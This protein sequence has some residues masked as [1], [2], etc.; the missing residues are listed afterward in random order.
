MSKRPILDLR[1]DD[2]DSDVDVDDEFSED[3]I[4]DE[5]P[6]MPAKK[7][8]PMGASA[9]I[10]DEA[11]VDDDAEDDEEEWEEGA[12]KEMMR[13]DREVVDED[14]EYRMRL[15]QMM[16]ARG[17]DEIEEY[18][19]KKYAETDD[20]EQVD[21]GN[22]AHNEEVKQQS[23]LPGVKDPN[24][25]RVKCRIGDEQITAIKLMRKF[26]NLE[27]NDAPLQIKSVVVP[28]GVK[29]CVYMEAYKQAHVKAALTGISS[30]NLGKWTQTMVP[31]KEM[32]DVL[33]VVNEPLVIKQGAWVRIKRGVYRDDLAQVDYLEQNQNKALCKVMPRVDYNKVRAVYREKDTAKN[34]K[35]KGRPVAKLFDADL[36]RSL[37]GELKKDGDFT[38]FEG[39]RYRNGFLYKNLSFSGITIDGPKPSLEELERF[40]QLPENV[41]PDLLP[42]DKK[43]DTNSVFA[44]GDMVEVCDG[45]LIHLTG[46]IISISGDKI[47]MMPHHAELKNTGA[48]E[49]MSKQ[50][51][52][53]FK[54]GDHVKV[55]NGKYENETGLVVRIDDNVA[56]L[57]ADT[58]FSEMKVRP[59]DM[60]LTTEM[61]A[62]VDSEGLYQIGDCIEVDQQTV[63]Y[64]IRIERESVR[65]VT[66]NGKTMSVKTIAIARK[67]P[68]GQALDSQ[69]NFLQ[70]R[71][72]VNV[73]DTG[74]QGEIKHIWRHFLFCFNRSH[75]ENNGIYVQK[76][77]NV[78]LAGAAKQSNDFS[79]GS[80]SSPRLQSPSRSPG[81]G[82]TPGRGG[83][84]ERN[85]RD[86]KFIG[87][88]VRVK[89]GPYKGYVG[90]VRDATENTARI[91]LH[92]DCKTISVDKSHLLEV[93]QNA[94]G[95]FMTPAT[96]YVNKTPAYGAFGSTTPMYGAAGS[97]TPMYG[98]GGQ[99]PTRGDRTPYEGARTPTHDGAGTPRH[100]SAWD[101]NY[102]NTPARSDDFPDFYE[103]SP[104]PGAFSPHNP[105]TP[106]YSEPMTP[107][108]GMDASPATP[109]VYSSNITSPSSP[110]TFTPS[111]PY[112]EVPS[113]SPG[114]SSLG[115]PSPGSD[116]PSPYNSSPMTPQGAN[117]N[118]PIL[119]IEVV[120]LDSFEEG[121]YTGQPGYIRAIQ[122]QICTIWLY[123]E[124]KEFE[125]MASQ[126]KPIVP[127]KQD[128]VVIINGN[129]RGNYGLLINIDLDDGIVKADKS[130]EL[131][132]IR[133]EN[134]AKLSSHHV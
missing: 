37:G 121:Q 10:L 78:L 51:R 6:K 43:R 3:E 40:D 132:I 115:P 104:S 68:S 26:I 100:N 69:R 99:T 85:Q 125:C 129:R 15:H 101:P 88:T 18:Y 41:D 12:D 33:K 109:G 28:V 61:N 19:R 21:T 35:K 124:E 84:R 29:G 27:I 60:Q 7:R 98:S 22:Y 47:T 79:G 106:G 113:P 44:A 67:L 114:G 92:T 45:E 93:A 96:P 72:I 31:I 55:I 64:I 80:L 77:R 107:G 82:M 71:N 59:R 9:F 13:E 127:S 131:R 17:E 36:V 102:P 24:L 1:S 38:I 34:K 119:G 5:G 117:D 105:Q 95:G 126:M 50:L 58:T 20:Q 123:E 2:D 118:W 108:Y 83:H 49:F 56:V 66:Q 75:G 32:V 130:Q 91:E 122:G 63:G 16:D 97:R 62:G 110:G 42:T 134:L 81:G 73:L 30:L 53:T 128:K 52:K 23:Q 70:A 4:E 120:M 103:N 65:I 111:S 54:M 87:K 94:N 90:I 25:W 57:I 76:S 112:S 133:L 86:V 116:A 74:T 11:E 46:T 14:K 39:G 89:Q 8:K 48:L